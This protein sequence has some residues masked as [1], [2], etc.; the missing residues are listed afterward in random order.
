MRSATSNTSA[1]LWLITTTP[2]PRSRRRLISS[3]TVA[4][5][6]DAER[7]RG[8]VE[9]HDL[10]LAQQRARHRDLLALASGEAA[11]LRAHA[12]DRDGELLEQLV[13]PVL[14]RRLVELARDRA[15]ARADDLL[16]EEQVGHHV[17]VVAQRQVLVD[18]RDPQRD[19]IAGAA[20]L[21]RPALEAGSCPRPA[22]WIP[23]IDFTSVD[24]PA[25]LSP[26]RATTSPPRT[27][28][29][30]PSSACTGPEALAHALE[31]EQRSR[32]SVLIGS[33]ASG[34]HSGP[35]PCS[36][37]GFPPSVHALLN[38][39]LQRSAAFTSP[40]STTV[41]TLR[42]EDRDRRQ[43]HRR[44]LLLAVVDLLVDQVRRARRRPSRARLR[45]A[46]RRRP[47]ACSPSRRS[48]TARR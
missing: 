43:D 31:R 18:G 24:L 32:R 23:E 16:P 47:P 40:P 2:R 14:H 27:S 4:V 19:G 30:T 7:G 34:P 37:I 41:L 5:C 13:R 22:A 17:E 6:G 44:H 39:P 36:A 10:R 25:P 15:G 35:L 28:K 45:S 46:P 48:C 26:T 38:L 9:Q 12:R 11:H 21:H 8:L 1:R 20:D 29:S 33:V 42:L 3:S